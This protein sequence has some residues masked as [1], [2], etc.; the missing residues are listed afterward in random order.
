MGRRGMF[1]G[2]LNNAG[3]AAFDKIKLLILRMPEIE[4]KNRGLRIP[5]SDPDSCHLLPDLP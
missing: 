2:A 4:C 5:P 3:V 1:G